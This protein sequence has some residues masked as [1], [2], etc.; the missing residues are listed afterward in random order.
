MQITKQAWDQLQPHVSFNGRLPPR[1]VYL[2]IAATLEPSEIVAS[3]PLFDSGPPTRWKHYFVTYRAIAC[4]ELQFD[5]EGSDLEE[6]D[7]EFNRNAKITATVLQAWVRPLATVMRFQIADVGPLKGQNLDWFPI[8]D[9]TLGFTDGAEV[10]IPG[11]QT[12]YIQYRDAIAR[13]DGFIGAIR[14]GLAF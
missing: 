4:T 3:W 12:L 11:Q 5:V 1:A 6:E 13:S 2:A 10:T 7:D 9:I 14:G 8:G